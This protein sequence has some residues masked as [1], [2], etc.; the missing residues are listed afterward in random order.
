MPRPSLDQLDARRIAL[1]KP[2]ALGDIVHALPVA[3]A[4]RQR[5]PHSEII[6]VVNR[7]YAPLLHGQPDISGLVEFDRHGGLAAFCRLLH[8]LRQTR[9]DLVVDLQGLLRT[10]LMTAACIPARRI[11]LAGAR[12]GA[13]WFYTDVILRP[14]DRANH[15]VDRYWLVAEA[16]GVGNLPKRFR[17]TLD[18]A[19]LAWAKQVWYRWPRPWLIVAPGAR[20]ETKRWP[21]RHFAELLRRYGG[22]AILVGSVDEHHL[23]DAIAREFPGRAVN[24]AGRTTLPQLAAL[25]ALADVVVGNDSGPLHLA[26][27]LGRHIVAPF[28]CTR[29]DRHGPYSMAM[30][31]S[32]RTVRPIAAA[33]ACQGSYRKRCSRLD[34]MTALTPDHLWPALREALSRCPLPCPAA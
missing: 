8:R 22:P 2:S 19:A 9:F 29:I 34:C 32:P 14:P 33:V 15:A 30:P 13:S 3:H 1:L 31:E 7:A 11:G 4:L 24:L 21:T 27:A 23:A 28:T 16:L 20:W 18:E 6:W 12:E 25:L 26:A 10:G 5:F 17:L